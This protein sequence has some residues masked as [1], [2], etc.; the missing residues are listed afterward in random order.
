MITK[1]YENGNKPIKSYTMDRQKKI[2]KGKWVDSPM[3]TR[4]DVS[5]V[6]PS[7]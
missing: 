6:A 3:I 7:T 4:D 1:K 2:Y 5:E